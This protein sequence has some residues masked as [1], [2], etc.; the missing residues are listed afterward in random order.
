MQFGYKDWT[1]RAVHAFRVLPSSLGLL[2]GRV[3]R[4]DSSHGSELIERVTG[5]GIAVKEDDDHGKAS[6]IVG[7]EAEEDTE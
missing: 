5:G 7:S 6:E 2:T 1:L 3:V 4:E